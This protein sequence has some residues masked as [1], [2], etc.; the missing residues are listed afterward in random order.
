MREYTK[1]SPLGEGYT[2]QVPNSWSP[3]ECIADLIKTENDAQL[4]LVCIHDYVGDD[5]AMAKLARLSDHL[6]EWESPSKDAIDKAYDIRD[7]LIMED[8]CGLEPECPLWPMIDA[9]L[10]AFQRRCNTKVADDIQSAVTSGN[11]AL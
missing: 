2:W 7:W 10:M 5:D 9:L 4:F 11:S 6:C 8:Y 3:V 1:L